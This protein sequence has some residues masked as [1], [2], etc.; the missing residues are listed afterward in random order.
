MSALKIWNGTAWETVSQSG[1][2]GT[3]PVTSVDARTGAVTLSDLYVGS[4]DGRR[5]AV[6]LSDLYVSATDPLVVTND[7]IGFTP[8]FATENDP[9]GAGMTP[10]AGGSIYGAYRFIAPYTM[11]IRW[12]FNWGS[13]GGNGGTGFMIF[14]LPPGYNA[15]GNYSYQY[16][17]CFVYRAGDGLLYEGIADV[18]ASDVWMRPRAPH[19]GLTTDLVTSQQRISTGGTTHPPNWYPNGACGAWGVLNTIQRS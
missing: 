17:N 8:K 7:W 14:G 10:G 9:S 19:A 16:L 11:A 15:S 6:T 18:V 12:R 1:P 4:V 2:P 5:G 13:S 3:A